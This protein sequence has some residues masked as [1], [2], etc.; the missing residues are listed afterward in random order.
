[1]K[2]TIKIIILIVAIALAIGGVMFYAKTQVAPPMATK[3]VNQYAKQIDNCCNAMANADQAG[4]D[5]IMTD[6]QSKIRI[7]ATEG[8]VEDEAANAATVGHLYA[9]VS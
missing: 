7:Y 2:V 6:A 4:M 8:K 1:M 9:R 3:A 5:S